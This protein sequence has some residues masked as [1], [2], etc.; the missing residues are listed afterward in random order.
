MSVKRVMCEYFSVVI[1]G[2]G[3]FFY[4]YVDVVALEVVRGEDL[5]E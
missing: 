3:D 2:L 4:F 5:V 1:V